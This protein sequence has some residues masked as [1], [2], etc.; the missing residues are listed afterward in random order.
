MWVVQEAEPDCIEKLDH[1]RSFGNEILH[2][3]WSPGS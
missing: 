1:F 3:D 2:E